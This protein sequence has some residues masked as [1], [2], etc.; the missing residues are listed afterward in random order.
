MTKARI[1]ADYVAGGTTATEFDYLDGLTSAA[2]GINDT[3][4]LTNK[5]LTSPTFT[6]TTTGH[7]ASRNENIY[8]TTN[9]SNAANATTVKITA[10][11]LTVWNTSNQFHILSSVDVSPAITASGANGLDTGSEANSTWY[12]YY[13]IYNGSTV[14]GLF[15]AS[16][17][18]P[19]MPSGYT[20]K[21]YIGAIYNQSGGDLVELYQKGNWCFTLYGTGDQDQNIKQMYSSSCTANTEHTVNPTAFIPP[22]ADYYRFRNQASTSSPQSYINVHFHAF[23]YLR[24]SAHRHGVNDSQDYIYIKDHSGQSVQAGGEHEMPMIVAQTF[25]INPNYTPGSLD[26][27]H[28]GYK[29]NGVE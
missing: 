5:T 9:I 3:Q 21:K 11:K 25:Y 22:N 19:T 20:Y 8:A 12:Y 16:Y 6:G 23:D 29:F 27:Y 2:V 24:Q 4:T 18:S 17:S 28:L 26:L 14:G 13:V 1:L 15:S 7:T 10:D